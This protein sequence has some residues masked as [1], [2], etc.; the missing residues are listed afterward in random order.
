MKYITSGTN[1]G[2]DI[3]VHKR[4]NSV[5]SSWSHLFNICGNYASTII[6][7]NYLDKDQLFFKFNMRQ[8]YITFYVI[9][10]QTTTDR[11]KH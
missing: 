7:H 4:I 5:T 8:L 11:A 6:Y 10:R 2:T 1:L 3:H 9:N